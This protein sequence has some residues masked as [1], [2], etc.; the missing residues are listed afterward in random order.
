MRNSRT[1]LRSRIA[2][3]TMV[4]IGSLRLPADAG[5]VACGV[6]QRQLD[7]FYF[8]LG[9]ES[10]VLPGAAFTLVCT[11]DTIAMGTIEWSRP[12]ISV[13]YPMLGGVEVDSCSEERVLINIPDI[14][15]ISAIKL[16]IDSRLP[17]GLAA[18][19]ATSTGETPGTKDTTRSGN[20]VRLSDDR[21]TGPSGPIDGEIDFESGRAAGGRRDITVAAPYIAALV[22]NPGKHINSQ[23]FLTTS[24]YYRFGD[25]HL[26]YLLPESESQ[27]QDHFD[28]GDSSD[29]RLYPYAPDR[30][31]GL[32]GNMA[33]RPQS[34]RLSYLHPGLEAAARFF[35]DVFARDR[36]K[37]EVTAM[38]TTAD[39]M[40]AWLP[41]L[42][43]DPAAGPQTLYNLMTRTEALEPAQQE[44]LSLIQQYLQLARNSSSTDARDYYL[45][46]V[47]RSFKEDLGAF[48]LFRPLERIV[49]SDR[50]RNVRTDVDGRL[51]I[52][53][54]ILLSYPPKSVPGGDE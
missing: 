28:K 42:A 35:A 50:L 49:P 13:S 23:G 18:T 47:D 11:D 54:L 38:D 19:T 9:E 40:I 20:P 52:S 34:I 27:R 41:L 48:P 46:L 30:G 3:L 16:Y 4:V 39:V 17:Q 8:S 43:S 1:L 37:V 7:R 12:G 2:I 21:G 14:D 24:A 36:I 45:N 10:L 25:M 33:D 22:P 6:L 31:R 29:V 51:V 26:P 32:M 5:T 15:S 53:E 44:A